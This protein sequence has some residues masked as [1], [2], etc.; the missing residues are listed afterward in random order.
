M[1]KSESVP[2]LWIRF[3]ERL[4]YGHETGF[5]TQSDGFASLVILMVVETQKAG[6]ERPNELTP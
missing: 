4:E 3:R 6:G 5:V 2:R 1:S